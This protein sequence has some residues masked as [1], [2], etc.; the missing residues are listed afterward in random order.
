MTD[1]FDNM[2]L[3]DIYNELEQEGD[4][5]SGGGGGGF[6]AKC[7]VEIGYKVYLGKDAVPEQ[8]DTFHSYPFGNKQAEKAAL[9]SAKKM[10]TEASSD[11][12]PQFGVQIT[13]LKEGALLRG[14]PVTWMG[15][16]YFNADWWTEASKDVVVPSLRDAGIRTWPWQ[17]WA[18]VGFAD[19][20]WKVAQGQQDEEMPDGT[21]RYKQ[22]AYILSLIHI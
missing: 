5:L 3:E 22:V 16:R 19:D 10:L 17:G 15:D 18:R 20:P 8:A 13:A 7:V 9:A 2:T 1:P 11:K 21:L 4:R 14:E 6:I 12:R